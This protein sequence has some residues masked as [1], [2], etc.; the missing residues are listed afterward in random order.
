MTRLICLTLLSMVVPLTAIA[1]DAYVDSQVVY[2]VRDGADAD[3]VA[4]SVGGQVIGEIGSANVFLMK[5]HL[6]VSV[7]TIVQML[8]ARPEVTMAQPNFIVKINLDQVS[9]PFVDQTS[10]AFVDG[11]MPAAYYHQYPGDRMRIDSAQ[12]LTDGAGAIVAIIDG[13]LD[14]R[15]PVFAGRL[16]PAAFDFIDIDYAPWVFGGITADHGTFVAGVIARA[17]PAAKL[18]IV[19]CFGTSGS[20]TSFDIAHGIYHAARNG[21][22]VINMSFGMDHY[23]EA[24]SNAASTAYYEYGVVMTAAAG[25]SADLQDRFPGSL[26]YVMNVA[27]VDSGDLKADFSNY[28]PSVSV[29]ASGVDVYST[30]TGG[31]VWGWWSGTSFAAPF[32]AGLAAMVKSVYDDAEP[33][34]VMDLISRTADTIDHLNPEYVFFLGSGRVNFLNAVYLPGDANGS[35]GIN[36]GDAVSIL[37]FV[38]RNGPAALPLEAADANCDGAINLADAVFLIQYIFHGGGEPE[39]CQY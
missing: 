15:H 34:F 18:M 12:T 24:I 32:A 19:R 25:N 17:A 6:P 20:G 14:N 36:I 3:T 13:G 4:G 27:A 31:D 8:D 35:G 23:D 39:R 1:S 5:Y 11:V 16:H 26:P 30:L 22:D 7:D 21:A 37:N 9:Q 33:Q 10:E 28:G 2:Q 38:F 29:N